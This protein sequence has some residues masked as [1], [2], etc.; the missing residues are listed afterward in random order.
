[1]SV[2]RAASE[3]KFN[4]GGRGFGVGKESKVGGIEI[5]VRSYA[6]KNVSLEILD[7]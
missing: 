5:V 2:G 6:L 3:S 7:P 1:M 4:E